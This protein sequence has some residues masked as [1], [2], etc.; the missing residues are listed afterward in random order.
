MGKGDSGAYEASILFGVR[1]P[2]FFMAARQARP[3]FGYHFCGGRQS[4]ISDGPES[5]E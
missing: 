1:G 2:V 5:P 3:Q 4:A